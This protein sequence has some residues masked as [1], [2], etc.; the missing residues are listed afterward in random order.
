LTSEPSQSNNK[1]ARKNQYDIT[2]TKSNE[3]SLSP[4]MRKDTY[5]KS[6]IRM[7]RKSSNRSSIFSNKIIEIQRSKRINEIQ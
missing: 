1:S 5:L 4:L 7:Q 3:K 6:P 2:I